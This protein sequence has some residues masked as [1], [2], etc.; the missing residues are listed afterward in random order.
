MYLDAAE[1]KMLRAIVHFAAVSAAAGRP[2][3]G[4]FRHYKISATRLQVNEEGVANVEARIVNRVSAGAQ[5]RWG[6]VLAA[7][8]GDADLRGEF[9]VIAFEECR[10]NGVYVSIQCGIVPSLPHHVGNVTSYRG[11]RSGRRTSGG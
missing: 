10:C 5:I 11:S 8:G 7:R 4:E 1:E 3:V 6:L 2:F 9:G